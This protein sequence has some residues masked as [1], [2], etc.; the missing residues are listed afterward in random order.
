MRPVFIIPCAVAFVIVI[1]CVFWLNGHVAP[2]WINSRIDR[3]LERNLPKIMIEK[4][5]IVYCR[6]KTDDFRFPLPQGT[7][8]ANLIVTGG[9]DTVDGSI[10]ALYDSTN[11]VTAHE[12][13]T[14]L[15]GKIQHGGQV[16]V[17]SISGGLLITFH[18]FGDR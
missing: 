12:Y 14:S 17:K 6:M 15:S 3:L 7:R 9:F 18:Y 11:Q 8:A 2:L 16:K 1:V 5:G 4:G 13:E 10:E